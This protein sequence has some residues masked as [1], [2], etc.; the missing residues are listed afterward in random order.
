MVR[1]KKEMKAKR[2]AA[3]ALGG[4]A[5]ICTCTRNSSA[6]GPSIFVDG[7]QERESLSPHQHHRM[8]IEGSTGDRGGKGES[9]S[10]RPRRRKLPDYD[11]EKRAAGC[12]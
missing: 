4:K 1:R 2:Q 8:V 3:A 12:A 11:S 6:L 7:V 10:N 5:T 9:G